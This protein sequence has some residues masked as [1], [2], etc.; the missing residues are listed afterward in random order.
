M[1][2]EIQAAI[3]EKEKDSTLGAVD[4][5][6]LSEARD[7]IQMNDKITDLAKAAHFIDDKEFE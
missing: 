6:L 4:Q 3:L 7:I 5:K 1:Y 2:Y